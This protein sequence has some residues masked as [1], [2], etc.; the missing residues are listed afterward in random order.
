MTLLQGAA[1]AGKSSVAVKTLKESKISNRTQIS[2][3]APSSVTHTTQSR[4]SLTSNSG[5]SQPPPRSFEARPSGALPPLVDSLG[6]I[7][8][9]KRTVSNKYFLPGL[10]S[11]ERWRR[12]GCG[13]HVLHQ[14]LQIH[15][16]QQMRE[17]LQ[18]IRRL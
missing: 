1:G 12:V 17:F 6:I 8:Y 15:V 11:E 9:V 14:K 13:L 4:S 2:T 5:S 3:A 16:Q 10:S 7:S 18:T